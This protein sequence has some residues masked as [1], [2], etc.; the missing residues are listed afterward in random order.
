[1]SSIETYNL[2][3]EWG[4]IRAVD[5]VSF[6]VPEAS[7]TVLLGPSG[8]GKSTILRMIA[9]LEDVTSGRIAIAG[10]DVTN[11]KPA[12][13][14]FLLAAERIDCEPA[15]CLVVEDAV[16]GVAAAKAA[17][18]GGSTLDLRLKAIS[19]TYAVGEE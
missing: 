1:M 10:E 7:L 2:I 6:H 12:P 16:S 9:G 4:R 15:D 19:Y 18:D 13:D 14:I 11:K 8:C 17:I 3:K 5:D